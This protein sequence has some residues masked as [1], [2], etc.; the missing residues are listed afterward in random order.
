MESE[1]CS[2]CNR[3]KENTP[4]FVVNGLTDADCNSL[5]RN[6][7]LANQRLRP[8]LNN[9]ETLQDLVDCLIGQHGE[10]LSIYNF[11]D[12]KDW[13][14]GLSANLHQL[15]SAWVCNE[16]GQWSEIDRI[17][18]ELNDI[19]NRLTIIEN[20]LEAMFFNRTVQLQQGRDFQVIFYNGFTTRR[21]DD[22]GRNNA[23][24]PSLDNSVNVSAN[25]TPIGTTIVVSA[26]SITDGT[27]LQHTNHNNITV[28]TTINANVANNENRHSWMFGIRFMGQYASL[29]TRAQ[30]RN[31][32]HKNVWDARP[33]NQPV[34][35]E[36]HANMA[37][38]GSINNQF[39]VADAPGRPRILFGGGGLL[40]GFRLSLGS[41]LYQSLPAT[42]LLGGRVSGEMVW[43]GS[44]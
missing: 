43:A 27:A 32:P 5:N 8:M 23:H 41:P 25:V 13:L 39:G 28:G 20:T 14:D 29:N 10:S 7:G 31:L 24:N 3:L 9:C 40:S 19:R 42:E 21:H 35:F 6:N 16:C 11:C 34:S 33:G 15:M 17:D 37:S 22:R 12:I 30:I 18:Q 44:L 26:I 2:A 36:R 4:S 38:F 1:L